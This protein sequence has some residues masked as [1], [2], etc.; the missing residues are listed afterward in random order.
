MPTWGPVLG[1]GKISGAV[2]YILSYH[3]PGEPGMA[4]PAGNGS[5]MAAAV[6][7]PRATPGGGNAPMKP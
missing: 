7:A 5:K 4:P 2:A 6:P 3:Q 1:A